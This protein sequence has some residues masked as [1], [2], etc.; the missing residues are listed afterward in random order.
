MRSERKL[1]P[2]SVIHQAARAKAIELEAEQGYKPSRKQIQEIKEQVIAKLMP[3]T[4]SIAR[5]T[6]VW[7]DPVN[8]WPCVDTAS[9]AVGNEVMGYWLRP[10]THFLCCH[11]IQNF[12]LVLP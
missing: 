12:R 7:V 4:F 5:D 9:C 11:F 10:L 2:S 8:R 3:R 6:Q 1:L